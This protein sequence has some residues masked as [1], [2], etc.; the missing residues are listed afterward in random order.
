MNRMLWFSWYLCARPE[1]GVSVE[2]RI[3]EKLAHLCALTEHV[4]WDM[5]NSRTMNYPWG[6]GWSYRHLAWQLSCDLIHNFYHIYIKY[7][8]LGTVLSVELAY[9][10]FLLLKENSVI[11]LNI[12]QDPKKVSWL[13]QVIEHVI[14]KKKRQITKL[15]ISNQLFPSIFFCF[16]K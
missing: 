1:T 5:M 11:Y 15:K 9:L 6:R 16:L 13:L 7:N 10:K 8:N 4:W 12:L 14:K 3:R 2:R